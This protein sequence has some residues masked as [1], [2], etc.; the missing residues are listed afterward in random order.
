MDFGSLAPYQGLAD[1]PKDWAEQ[2]ESV[3]W[4]RLRLREYVIILLVMF[5]CMPVNL[6]L[7]AHHRERDRHINVKNRHERE[8][9][10]KDNVRLFF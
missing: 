7:I 4:P 2:E 10:D 9:I 3:Y 1:S 5:F 6:W 8:G